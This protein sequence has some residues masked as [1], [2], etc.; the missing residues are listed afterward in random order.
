MADARLR[1]G[2][3]VLLVL[4]L[5]G[6]GVTGQNEGLA[7]AAQHQ[8]VES[9]LLRLVEGEDALPACQHRASYIQGTG[10]LDHH[11]HDGDGQLKH[12]IPAAHV[13]EVQDPG[14]LVA[15]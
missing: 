14:D 1:R 7:E 6:H 8:Q 2:H 11:V 10:V 12:I 15:G 13:A 5:L 4:G 3:Q 9:L